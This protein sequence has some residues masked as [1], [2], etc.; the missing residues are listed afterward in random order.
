[1]YQKVCAHR[2]LIT[3]VLTHYMGLTILILA[4]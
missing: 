3:L 1:M 2:S 4:W